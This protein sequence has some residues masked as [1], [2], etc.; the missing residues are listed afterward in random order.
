MQSHIVIIDDG[1]NPDV[2]K[3]PPLKYSLVVE[4][5]RITEREL[6]KKIQSHGTVC[7]GI[8]YKYN[9]DCCITSI[10][11]LDHN[12][13][14]T[15]EDLNIAIKWCIDNKV[16]VIN[17][18]IGS[19]MKIDYLKM[20]SMIIRAVRKGI[21]IVAAQNNRLRYTYPASMPEVI[22]VRHNEVLLAGEYRLKKS[23]E[24]GID[25]FASSAHS[26]EKVK[27][28]WHEV[29]HCNSFSV[30]F[31]AAEVARIKHGMQ[32]RIHDNTEIFRQL[33]KGEKIT[34]LYENHGKYHTFHTD[35]PPFIA[36]S[37]SEQKEILRFVIYLDNYLMNN[38]YNGMVVT[39][40]DKPWC[41]KYKIVSQEKDIMEYVGD[42]YII[43]RQDLTIVLGQ[44]IKE[45][46][47]IVNIQKGNMLINSPSISSNFGLLQMEIAVKYIFN[48]LIAP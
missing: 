47:I 42:L 23:S 33:E 27:N 9:N 32:N 19:V 44:D 37:G 18:S 43:Y 21:T 30:P 22:G 34:D 7:A 5:D 45:A 8:I 40:G 16:D 39:I 25:I 14:G 35:L 10:K 20:K 4:N 31:I 24:D 1:V 3:L 15:L 6:Q 41:N 29:S 17:L 12:L 11:V 38:G 2:Y 28:G 48:C 13:K 46:D 36:V 26:I